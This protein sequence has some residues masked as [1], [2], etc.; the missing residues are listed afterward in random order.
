MVTPLKVLW[1]DR[2][3]VTV[4]SKADGGHGKTKLEDKEIYKDIPCRIS[5][6]SS[7]PGNLA[8]G[9]GSYTQQ[10]KLF[11]DKSLNIPAGSKITVDRTGEIYA[12][13]SLPALY[14]AHQEIQL[15]LYEGP[16][17]DG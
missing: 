4:K 10:I 9:A 13:C 3:T 11:L 6:P 2:C 7:P 15:K 12:M 1:T 14:S 8:Y 17:F 5:F 16:G